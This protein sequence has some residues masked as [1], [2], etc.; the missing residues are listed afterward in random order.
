MAMRV[1]GMELPEPED[2]LSGRAFSQVGIDGAIESDFFDWI[3]ASGDSKD[4]IS[5]VARQVAR[6]DFESVKTDVLKSLYE[7]LIDPEQRH[8]LGEYYTP[9]WLA[10]RMC[11]RAIDDPLHQ[12]VLDPACG[13]GTFL[14]HS[15]RKFLDV[16]EVEGISGPEALERCTTSVFGIDIH[17]VAVQIARVTYL[18][19]MGEQRLRRRSTVSLPVYLGDSLQWN[20]QIFM[21]QA[22][23]RIEVPD[24]KP[25]EFPDSITRDSGVF[26]DV[27]NFMIDLGEA[28]AEPDGLRSWL[29]A[30]HPIDER[31]EDQLAS[32]YEHLRALRRAGKNHVWK[33]VARN[34]SKPVSLAYPPRRVD[35]LIG[36]PPW[37]SYRFMSKAMQG[38]FRKECTDR[39]I[40]D[41]G[42]VAT[43]QDLSAY[44]FARC[45]QLYLKDGGVI[46]FVM[47]YAALN[48]KQFAG[49]RKGSFGARLG[50]NPFSWVRFE[51]A[52]AMDESVQPVFP[53]PSCVLIARCTEYGKL[54][55]TIW[56]AS[57]TLPGRDAPPEV[58][59]RAL[60]WEESPW[61]AAA[62]FSGGSPYRE[63]FHNGATL[64]P[65]LLC[66]VEEVAP[67]S[68][69]ANS[70]APLVRSR[71]NNLEKQPW[72][73]MPALQ[74][75]IE[76]RF[77]R[78]LHLGESIAPFR[79]LEPVTAVIP[80]D[81]SLG[82]LDAKSAQTR[83]YRYLARWMGDAE[84]VW[85]RRNTRVTFAQ[86]INY[87]HKLSGQFPIRAERVLYSKA[88]TIP[89]AC[90]L[91]DSQAV[92]DHK[93]YWAALRDGEAEYLVTVLNSDTAR[94]RVAHLQARGQW[95]A[96]DFDK[97]I[98]GLPIPEFDEANRLHQ[99]LAAACRRAEQVA[100]AVPLRE[101]I[102]FTAVR[103]E[104]RRA[105]ADDG[106]AA[107]MEKLVAQLLD[108]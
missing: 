2:L 28:D 101:G 23:L 5:R 86:Q 14:F 82:L 89:A 33:Y 67:G 40:W 88:G 105:L 19:A 39:N 78:P 24:E 41:G 65:R 15:V 17:P 96:R 36:N 8:E 16:A 64:Y 84:R 22:M 49:F 94:S 75:N 77:L 13:S 45:V 42:N 107:S 83:G 103:R 1:L 48:R 37:L 60:H 68:L 74:M 54:P 9:D 61:P 46:A 32:A 35:V 43:Q 27:L 38:R 25:L 87:L 4:F 95:G 71:K 63:A 91:R 108:G 76:A 6:F 92:I 52:W 34:Q 93:L 85:S 62:R 81:D 31:D 12:R 106:V 57:G 66:V 7:S 102:H 79:P 20:T 51:E 73:G 58:A 70:E 100:A 99:R 53:V 59:G 11:D 29:R 69:G 56:R 72:K 90:V 97:L 30:N 10:A 21:D 104:I 18:L 44:F 98:F 50:R 80:W 47:P 26:D 55:L 3:L